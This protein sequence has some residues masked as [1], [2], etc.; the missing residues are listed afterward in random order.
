MKCMNVITSS[1]GTSFPC[2]DTCFDAKT[3]SK[4][5]EDTPGG[6]IKKNIKWYGKTFYSIDPE[7]VKKKMCTFR[8]VLHCLQNDLNL[9]ASLRYIAFGAVYK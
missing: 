6:E 4:C 1:H 2:L 5:T 3:F 8:P 9:S 7:C